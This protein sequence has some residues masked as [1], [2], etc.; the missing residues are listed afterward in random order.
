MRN[1]QGICL[2]VT[3]SLLGSTMGD[4][5]TALHDLVVL[6]EPVEEQTNP[7]APDA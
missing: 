4:S 7:V 6:A 2:Q 5:E 3:R 1:I